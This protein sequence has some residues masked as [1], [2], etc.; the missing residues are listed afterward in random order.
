S[1]EMACNPPRHTFIIYGKP[2]QTLTKMIP[3]LAQKASVIQGILAEI[4]I[5][6]SR[7]L[8]PPYCSFNSPCHA[9]IAMVEGRDQG[10][11]RT[12]LYIFAS[13]I[14]VLFSRIASPSPKAYDPSV[15]MT[16]KHTVHPRTGK[17]TSFKLP[18]N[19][20]K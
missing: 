8:I 4:P 20:V 9:K 16:A 2:S 5:A 7:L 13:F 11:I 10:I 18:E 19:T 3:I 12:A 6:W 1:L 14:L 15:L 17:K